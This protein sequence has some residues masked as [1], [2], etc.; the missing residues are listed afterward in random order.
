MEPLFVLGAAI[1]VLASWMVLRPLWLKDVSRRNELWLCL[2]GLATDV[3]HGDDAARRVGLGWALRAL[4]AHDWDGH[5][6]D[7]ERTEKAGG[8]FY[9]R[10]W[11]G[12]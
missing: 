8:P 1:G 10:L 2:A 7:Y 12:R 3:Q 4:K 5:W 11:T 9:I 6:A